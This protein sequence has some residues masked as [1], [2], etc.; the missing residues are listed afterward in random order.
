[1]R[2]IDKTAC[3]VTGI[4]SL[5]GRIG[6]TLTRTVRR[7]EVLEHRHSLLKVGDNRVLDN[8]GSLS[9]GL[10]RLSHKSTHTAKLLDLRCRTTGSG[11]Q[12][13]IYRVESLL[14]ARNLLLDNLGYLVVD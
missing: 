14:V 7:D 5:Q 9:S 4:G 1:M 8:L 3:K 6:K 12:H 2:H 10:L 11:I 13:H